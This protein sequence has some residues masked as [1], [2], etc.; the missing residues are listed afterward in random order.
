MKCPTQ[1][2]QLD[3]VGQRV[4]F[5]RFNFTAVL[6]QLRLNIVQSER[7]IEIRF[8]ANVRH[9]QRN[10]PRLEVLL[11]NGTEPVLI[12][13]PSARQGPLTHDDVMLL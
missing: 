5:R 13:R 12:Q 2:L 10:N 7:S 9:R 4:F 8:L 1:I 3:Q 11:V 6:P